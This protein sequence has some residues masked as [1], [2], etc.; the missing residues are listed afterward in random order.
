MPV[1]TQLYYDVLKLI[2]MRCRDGSIFQPGLNG[3]PIKDWIHRKGVIMEKKIAVIMDQARHIASLQK[4]SEIVVYHY[5]KDAWEPAKTIVLPGLYEGGM[6]EIRRKMGEVLKELEDCRIIAGKN[7]SG[8]IY[9]ILDSAGLILSEM[10]TFQE[11]ELEGLYFCIEEELKNMEKKKEES[12]SIPTTP[13]ETEVKGNYFFDFSLLKNT[14]TGHS[15]KNT[16]IPFL[17]TTEFSSLEIVCDHVMPWFEGEMKKRGLVYEA[18]ERQDK[19]VSIL[20]RHG[21]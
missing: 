17:N 12:L 21:G 6:T 16:I 14:G 15:S 9:N 1:T 11:S 19:K 8:F 18:R 3:Y 7:I 2:D 4:A 20:V 13:V 5:E 10:D